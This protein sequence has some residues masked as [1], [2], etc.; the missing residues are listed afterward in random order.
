MRLSILS[1][2]SPSFKVVTDLTIPNAQAYAR[3]WAFPLILPDYPK[4]KEDHGWGRISFMRSHL[5]HCD[6][7]LYKDA[8]AVFMNMGKDARDFCDDGYEM[9]FAFDHYGLQSGVIFL[10]NC[11]AVFSALDAII[12]RKGMDIHKPGFHG[13]DQ[14]AIVK[15]LGQKPEYQDRVPIEEMQGVAKVRQ[16][17]KTINRYDDDFKDGDFIYHAVG[18]SETEEPALKKSRQIQAML[19]RVIR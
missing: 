11:P 1:P 2:H 9:G 18:I 5:K 17:D 8:D 6:W 14:G 4:A 16:M 3:K 19:H 12:A 15:I 13:A 7:L 10:K